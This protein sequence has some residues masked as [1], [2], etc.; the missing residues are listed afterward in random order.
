MINKKDKKVTRDVVDAALK[1]HGFTLGDRQYEMT[2]TYER[3]VENKKEEEKTVKLDTSIDSIRIVP[4]III[5][6]SCVDSVGY[7]LFDKMKEF[8]DEEIKQIRR[9]AKM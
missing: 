5:P 7:P 2:A 1:N 4:N 8:V 3:R 6:A 9:E